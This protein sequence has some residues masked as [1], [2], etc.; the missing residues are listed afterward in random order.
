M[1]QDFS[2][3]PAPAPSVCL[4]HDRLSMRFVNLRKCDEW[5]ESDLKQYSSY[6]IPF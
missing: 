6:S 3:S 4:P 2:N 5:S 1:S